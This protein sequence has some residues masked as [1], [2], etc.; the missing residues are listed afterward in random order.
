[1]YL[2]M[3]QWTC[4][5]VPGLDTPGLGYIRNIPSLCNPLNEQVETSVSDSALAS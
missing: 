3:Y 2:M 1:M 4:I 5:S